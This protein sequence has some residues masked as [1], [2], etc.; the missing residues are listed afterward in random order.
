VLTRLTRALA[1]AGKPGTVLGAQLEAVR[2]GGLRTAVRQR[3]AGDPREELT[4][5]FYRRVW[6]EAADELGAEVVELGG[7]YLELRK[8]DKRTRVWRQLVE[9]DDFVSL[10]LAGDKPVVHALLA[11]AGLPVPEYVEFAVHDL[12]TPRGVMSGGGS[13][14]VKPASGTAVGTGV[15][16]GVT[17]DASFLRARLLAARWDSR[18]LLER[19]LRGDVHRLL[20]LDGRLLDTVRRRRPTVV[21]DGKSAVRELIH[22]ENARRREAGGAEGLSL[23]RVDLDTTLALRKQGLSLGS[24]PVTGERVP[25]KTVANQNRLEDNEQVTVS[26]E[27]AAIAV[28]AAEV[29]G[30]R[31]AGVDMLD[32]VVL[33]VNGTPG[34]NQHYHVAS[35]SPSSRV[36]LPVLRTLLS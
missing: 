28:R 14:V 29:V 17:D 7:E 15:T 9:L 30:L 3:R 26:G 31:L 19:Q 35:P 12:D 10:Q 34:F 21:G 22:R 20:V 8:D 25:V 32:G 36:A 5:A 1:V 2:A 13:F 16:G 18:L 6:R 23:L 33:E 11:E 27:L 24:V 4:A